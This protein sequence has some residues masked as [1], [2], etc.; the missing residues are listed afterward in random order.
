MSPIYVGP[1]NGGRKIYGPLSS[2]P[3]SGLADGDEYYNTTENQKYV[4]NSA[5]SSF[6]KISHAT[7]GIDFGDVFNDNSAIAAFPLDGNAT[8][9]SGTIFQGTLSG[10][11]GSSN[12]SSSGGKYSS[13]WIGSGS[14]DL[15]GTSTDLRPSGAHSLSFWYK[16]STTGSNNKRLLTVK[17]A[18][19]GSGWNNHSN[20][21]GF[22]TVTGSSDLNTVGSVARV[23]SIPDATVNNNQ[24][25]HLAYTI[26]AAN[27][28]QM[29]L[30]GSAYNNPHTGATESRSFNSGSYLAVTTYDGGTVYNSTCSIDQ[31]RLF[32]R[33]LTSSEITALY[34]ES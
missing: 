6:V 28:W 17:G 22:Y 15:I 33:V 18:N 29:Y 20:S 25:H 13:Y 12:F 23:A 19:I 27:S 10:N 14:T 11:N 2:A 9:L 30:D 32:N 1:A 3:S 31:I 16:S 34:N 21:I 5:L 7:V 4:Y 24:W 8:S 26:S